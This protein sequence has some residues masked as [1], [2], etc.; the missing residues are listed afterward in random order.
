MRARNTSGSYI[1]E[2]H[3][4]APVIE[5]ILRRLQQWRNGA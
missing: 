2:F 5:D 4:D 1:A 3:V